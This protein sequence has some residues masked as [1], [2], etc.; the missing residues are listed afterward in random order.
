V[1]LCEHFHEVLDY[2]VLIPYD[3]FLNN[4]CLFLIFPENKYLYTLLCFNCHR[5]L[6]ERCF[7]PQFE[8]FQKQQREELMFRNQHHLLRG[9]RNRHPISNGLRRKRQNHRQRINGRRHSLQRRRGL[10]LHLHGLRSSH[11]K[12]NGLR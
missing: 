7:H 10:L 1:S 2:L 3:M 9:Q 12:R 6:F 5:V 4:I 8:R 11:R